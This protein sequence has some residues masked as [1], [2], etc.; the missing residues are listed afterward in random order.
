METFFL[1]IIFFHFTAL[2]SYS[3]QSKRKFLESVH[4]K[5]ANENLLEWNHLV[6][7]KKI[8][9][10]CYTLWQIT[11]SSPLTAFRNKLTLFRRVTLTNELRRRVLLKINTFCVKK[12][13]ILEQFSSSFINRCIFLKI[14][15][16]RKE[17][18][19]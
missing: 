13:H 19:D 11:E 6:A 18:E 1:S 16:D 17:L 4:G 15:K 2:E 5:S 14:D 3:W 12:T 10:T 9:E 8:F 7:Q